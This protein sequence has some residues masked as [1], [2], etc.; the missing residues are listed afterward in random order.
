SS[1]AAHDQVTR[2]WVFWAWKMSKNRKI[3]ILGDSTFAEIA[4]EFFMYD[5]EYEVVAFSVEKDYLTKANLF[6]LPVVPLEDLPKLYPPSSHH[7]Y[8]AIVFTQ[9]NRLRTRLYLQA[10]A[11]GYAPASYI[12]SHARIL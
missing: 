6:N 11:E 5:S 1:E 10:K 7:V 4:Y 9:N 2:P 3:I 12:S 8:A